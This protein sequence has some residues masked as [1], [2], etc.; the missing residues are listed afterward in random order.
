[1]R[2]WYGTSG[3]LILWDCMKDVLRMLESAQWSQGYAAL[4]EKKNLL[5]R[6]PA[7]LTFKVVKIDGSEM[8]VTKVDPVP[9][10]VNDDDSTD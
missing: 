1:M 6:R 4:Y 3:S 5:H 8:V 7:K 10:P 2:K 9:V